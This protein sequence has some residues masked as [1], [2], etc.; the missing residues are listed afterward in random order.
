VHTVR[1]TRRLRRH[2]LGMLGGY[3]V[4]FFAGMILNLF[5]QVPAKHPGAGASEYFGG[6]ARGLAWALSD[7]GG[8]V[9]AFHVYLAVGLVM[10][11]IGLF[12]V[13]IRSGSRSWVVASAVTA[14]FTIGALFNG[15]SFI[16]YNHDISSLIMATCWLIAVGSLGY[17]LIQNDSSDTLR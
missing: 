12:V 5:V 4:Q 14:L 11:S 8:W 2:A 17:V 3:A 13:S 15:L 9:L 7:H 10:G 6:A 16:N 1:V